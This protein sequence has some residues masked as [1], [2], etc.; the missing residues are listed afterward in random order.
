MFAPMMASACTCYA[1]YSP[2]IADFSEA[3]DV[4]TGKVN[5]VLPIKRKRHEDF[6]GDRLVTFQ[7][8]KSYK[9]IASSTRLISLYSDYDSSSCS[10]GVDSRKGPRVGETWIV[11]ANKTETPQMFF[12]GSCN[13]SRKIRSDDQLKA[14]ES[15]AFKFTQ[16]Q[17]IVGTVV[18]NYMN[19]A[20]E[21]EIT[22]TGEGTNRTIKVD[23]DG[24]YWFP[25]ER[26]GKF[27]VMGRI[28]FRTTLI[29]AVLFPHAFGIAG[30]ETRF[31]YTVDLKDD[32][33]H[34]NEINVNDPSEDP[35]SKF[36]KDAGE[37]ASF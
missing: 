16:R 1:S 4:F 18:R 17:G 31:T 3:D 28:P 9:G 37:P 27:S 8:V 20:K 34:Y 21:V 36:K 11:V 12:G 14:I 19:L 35:F 32:E 6:V 24:Y 10:F 15:E 5:S 2:W 33:Y 22:L 25:L 30:T 7:V 29:S 23:G 26:A 13:A